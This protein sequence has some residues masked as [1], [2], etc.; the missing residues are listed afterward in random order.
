LV[1]KNPK[2]TTR[3]RERAFLVGVEI[4][5]SHG[6]LSMWD[7]LN[8]LALLADTAGLNVIGQ[9]T[10]KL[11]HPNSQTFIGPGKAEEIKALVEELHADVV[12]FDEELSPRHLRELE[13]IMGDQVS[14]V[15]RTA[16][17]LDI[18][19]QHASTREG[20]LQVELA[21]YEYRLPRLTRAWTHLA[22]QSGGGAGRTGSVGGVGLRGPGE[23]Q[24]EVD[25]RDIRRRINHLKEELEKVRTHRHLY[26]QR[27]QRSNIPVITLVGYTNAGKSTLLNRIAQANV[28]VANQLFATLDPTTRRVELPG[29]RLVLFTD[30]V[31]FIQKLPTALVASFRAT[32]EEIAD[33]DLLLNIIDVTHVNALEQ[34]EAV[35]QTLIE[36][37]ADHI[38][39]LTVLNKIDQLKNPDKATLSINGLPNAVAIS[40]LTGTGIAGLLK[41]INDNLFE[42]YT[43]L[44][45][46]LPYQ[47]GNLI[48]LFHESGQIEK[49]EHI[50]GGV[51]IQGRLPGRFVARF[52][53][54]VTDNQ[55]DFNIVVEP[56]NN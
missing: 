26:R 1:K 51:I 2:P 30:T 10:Q 55:P 3:S 7:S 14:I 33:A 31:G 50:R 27:R 8:E 20:A 52:Q 45:V 25:R 32:L 23:T 39:V 9:T 38:P 41:T 16:L 6:L 24:L 54:F 36:I 44:M 22:R 4:H 17:I 47:Q 46:K 11:E 12:L 29:G 43:S 56:D 15:D 53:T 18:F 21:Q 42:T 49:F 48:S 5:S 19:A 40:A 34:A 13:L 37:H 35:H 28:Y